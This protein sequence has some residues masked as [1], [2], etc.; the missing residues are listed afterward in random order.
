MQELLEG[1]RLELGL[2][3]VARVTGLLAELGRALGKDGRA[4]GLAEEADLEQAHGTVGDQLD[5]AG[6]KCHVDDDEEVRDLPLNPAP[7]DVLV[8]EATV[9]GRRDRAEDSDEREHSDGETTPLRRPDVGERTGDDGRTGS[10]EASGEQTADDDR[11]DVLRK[12]EGDEPNREHDVAAKVDGIATK[13]LGEGTE[14]HG[15]DGEGCWEKSQIEIA[16][17]RR[18]N[19]PLKTNMPT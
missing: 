2:G 14:E 7:A 19:V 5:P 4:T 18:S 15:D 17:H 8:D 6:R 3:L 10:T 13:E 12:R 1:G 11:A 16:V 9:K